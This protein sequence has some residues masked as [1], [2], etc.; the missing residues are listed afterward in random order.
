MA[1]TRKLSYRHSP[2]VFDHRIELH[3]RIEDRHLLRGAH[4]FDV[5][6]VGLAHEVFMGFAPAD[7][8][9]AHVHKLDGEAD[10]FI[11]KHGAAAKAGIAV[12]V[13]TDGDVGA[14]ADV[15]VSVEIEQASGAGISVA[16]KIAADPIV[17]IAEAVRK[18][19]ALGIEEK[20]RGFDGGRGDNDEIG[21]LLVET[22][23]S[24]EIGD[25]GDFTLI[26]GEDFL[27]H[28][29]E[30]QIAKAGGKSVR[31]DSVVRAALGIHF[32]DETY[33][34]A[35]AHAGR[36]AVVRNAIAE[37][38]KV[39]GMEAETLRGGLEDFVLARGRERGHGKRLGARALEGVVGDIAGNADLVLSF[40]VEGLE[41]VVRDG[42]ILES[43]ARK[44]AVGGAQAE[45]FGLVAPGHGAIS[46]RATTDASRVVTVAAF[47]GEDDMA[48]AIEVHEDAGIAFVIGSGI[49]AKDGRALIAEVI[50][51]AI[52]GGVPAAALEESDV[53]AGLGKFLGDNAAAGS[54]SDDDDIYARQRHGGRQPFLV[55]SY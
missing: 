29:A 23:V 27:G 51:A 18:K 3:A 47:T 32:T 24:V 13:I 38:G 43:A 25:A 1:I 17:A 28:A 49:I 2:E 4:D 33:A 37:H 6:A 40:L 14:G 16:L 21:G 45:I 9:R 15:V 53:E 42:P 12:V 48:I 8:F 26:V 41:I 36:A 5:A 11:G 50:L 54:G 22:V 39:K 10:E 7:T 34:P 30:A 35:A 46:E 52:V 55:N 44:T 20:S 19:P 31:D